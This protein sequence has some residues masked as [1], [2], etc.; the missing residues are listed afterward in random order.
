MTPHPDPDTLPVPGRY[1][2]FKGN[3]Y[4]VIGLAHDSESEAWH[5]IYHPAG[6]PAQWWSRALALFVE[7]VVW[8][9]GV[10]RPRFVLQAADQA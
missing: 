1:L 5:V 10:M 6:Q 8:P 9:D 3:P 7:P 2:H 4:Q